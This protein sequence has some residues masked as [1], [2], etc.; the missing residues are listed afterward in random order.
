VPFDRLATLSRCHL[1]WILAWKRKDFLEQFPPAPPSRTIWYHGTILYVE[2]VQTQR[3]GSQK[4]RKDPSNSNIAYIP[5]TYSTIIL[6]HSQSHLCLCITNT[7]FVICDLRR[8]DMGLV[9]LAHRDTKKVHLI[10]GAPVKPKSPGRR[11]SSAAAVV[12]AVVVAVS[13]GT[14]IRHCR[15]HF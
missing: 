9:F 14:A 15:R 6:E 3:R 8:S 13:V 12:P 11:S 5:T 2:L 4:A 10:F 7:N 1:R